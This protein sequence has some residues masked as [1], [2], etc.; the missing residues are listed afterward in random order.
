MGSNK[1]HMGNGQGLKINYVGTFEITLSIHPHI[2]LTLNNLLHV[3]SITKNLMFV[4]LFAKGN[5]V[6]F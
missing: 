6:Y 3:P 5:K 4:S 2:T 1:V